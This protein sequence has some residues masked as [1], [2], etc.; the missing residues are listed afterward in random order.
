M[1]S[2]FLQ[3][4]SS[5][6]E[7][8]GLGWAL[9]PITGVCIW[10]R[11]A[12]FRGSD[13]DT[14]GSRP[15]EHEGRDWRDAAVSRGTPATTEAR[16]RQRRVCPQSST[17]SMGLLAPW[18][19]TVRLTNNEK[20]FCHFKLPSI[21]YHALLGQ[22]SETNTITYRKGGHFSP[23]FQFV[24]KKSLKISLVGFCLKNMVRSQELHTS[25][26]FSNF[27]E[28]NDIYKLWKYNS[29]ICLSNVTDL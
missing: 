20:N 27:L 29:R 28:R 1:E 22:S 11:R 15:C 7:H 2:G 3:I 25:F 19:L 12:I 14:V 6:D 10:E 5:H 9:N 26:S 4:E 17:E 8:I 23:F 21:W 16:K 24:A 18:L 13:S